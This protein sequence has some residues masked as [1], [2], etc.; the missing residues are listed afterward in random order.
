MS[1][2][3]KDAIS[4]L[5]NRYSKLESAFDADPIFFWMEPAEPGE[6]FDGDY[7]VIYLNGIRGNWLH[8]F[9]DFLQFG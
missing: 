2:R 7:K 8:P 3:Q 9:H 1:H 6:L 4:M 5:K